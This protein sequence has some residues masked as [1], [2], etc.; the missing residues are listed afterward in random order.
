MIP[1]K[2]AIS[3]D[4]W[5]RCEYDYNETLY[6]FNIK[7]LSF[8]KINLS[9]VD[10]PEK[11]KVIDK[12]A[13]YWIMGLECINLITEPLS[14]TYTTGQLI[15]VDQ[16][17]FKFHTSDDVHLRLWSDFAKKYLLDCFFATDLVPKTKAVGAIAFQ[18]PDDDEAAYSISL[19]KNG[20]IREA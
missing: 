2:E 16:D 9:E 11:I 20:H 3:N 14:P 13:N 6:K 5:L 18:L 4:T 17:G 7:I 1:I 8:R 10:E 12:N 15:L 19:K